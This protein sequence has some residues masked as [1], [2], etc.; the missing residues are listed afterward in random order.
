MIDPEN[1]KYER[2]TELA[3]LV[4]AVDERTKQNQKQLDRIE[5]ILTTHIDEEEKTFNVLNSSM[6]AFR[7]AI[8][9]KIHDAI[10]PL[11]NDIIKYKGILGFITAS[12][13]GIVVVVGVFKEAIIRWFTGH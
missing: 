7:D 4:A 9:T 8:E 3:M 2:R 12:V 10:D 1:E 11:K 5:H 13:G 6:V